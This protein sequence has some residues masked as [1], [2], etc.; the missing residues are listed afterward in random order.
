[1]KPSIIFLTVFIVLNSTLG[2]GC[3]TVQ[4]YQASS[5][6]STERVAS[7]TPVDTSSS[8][9]NKTKLEI[10]IRLF[11]D[12]VDAKKYREAYS[13]FS[14]TYQ[15]EHPFE[16][17]SKGYV[18]TIDHSITSIECENGTCIADFVAKEITQKNVRRQ[19]YVIKYDFVVDANAKLI[20]NNGR[21]LTTE[22]V[23][24]VTSFEEQKEAVPMPVSVPTLSPASTPILLQPAQE[25]FCCK[26]CTKGKACGDSCISRS[27]TCHKAP[28]CACDAN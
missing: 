20:I 3:N 9:F 15:K 17:W 1:M 14:E 2:A 16:K 10:D 8:Q 22:T 19:R 12:Y 7:V 11:L 24:V 21:Q 25:R 6:V 5:G 4:S 18:D 27:Y 13:L 26:Y 28:G 23:E